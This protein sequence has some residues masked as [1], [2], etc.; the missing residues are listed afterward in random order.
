M[1]FG[2]NLQNLRNKAGLSQSELA[3][4]A[5]IPVKTIQSWEI[6]RRTPRWISLLAKLAKGLNVPIESL[7]VGVDKEAEQKPRADKKV[8]SQP[9]KT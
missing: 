9:R 6:S 4:K 1:S 8:R 5:D 7:T 3:A 2:R